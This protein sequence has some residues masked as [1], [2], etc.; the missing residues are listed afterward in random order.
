MLK[1]GQ[2]PLPSYIIHNKKYI[3]NGGIQKW[4]L[5]TKISY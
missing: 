3:T 1:K 5:L 2:N 4:A